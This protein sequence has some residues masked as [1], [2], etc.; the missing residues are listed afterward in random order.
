[1]FRYL[2]LVFFLSVLFCVISGCKKEQQ[3]PPAVNFTLN[4]VDPLAI[5]FSATAQDV[6]ASN[7]K[8][9]GFVWR[10]QPMPTKENSFVKVMN[11]A[12]VNFNFKLATGLEADSTYYA[13]AY[14][15]TKSKETIY[16]QEISFK[17]KKGSAINFQTTLGEYTWDDE[18]EVQLFNDLD[19][20][21]TK[22]EFVLDKNLKFVPLKI[23]GN[24]IY[25]KIPLEAN[26]ASWYSMLDVQLY[27]A[28]IASVPI[29]FK[30]P[31]IIQS[32][33]IYGT[34]GEKI[35]L[36]G[37]NFHPLK[38]R[39]T[40]LFGNNKFVVLNATKTTLE[41]EIAD[42]QYSYSDKITVQTSPVL[43]TISEFNAKVYKHFKRIAPFP[44]PARISP[45]V[46]EAN[47][48]MY[49]GL[50]FGHFASILQDMWEYT[51]ATDSWKQIADLP[52]VPGYSKAMVIDGKIYV[53]PASVII[54]NQGTNY[55]FNYDSGTN[56]WKKVS[57]YPNYPLKGM[58]AFS[59][60]NYGYLLS[61]Y[62]YDSRNYQY[63][64]SYVM[65]YD[66]LKNL[67]K[68]IENFPGTPRGEATVIKIG[69]KVTLLAGD[70]YNFSVGPRY[71]AD[72]WSFD[73]NTEKWVKLKDLSPIV[74]TPQFSFT[75]NG[76]GY[77][78][79]AL[80]NTNS[81]TSELIEY[82]PETDTY[83]KVDNLLDQNKVFAGAAA[84]G[85][86][87]YILCGDNNSGNRGTNVILRFIP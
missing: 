13:R 50:G 69:N 72:S 46:F 63:V 61:G 3:D 75:V 81:V 17:G 26:P 87:G 20:D 77:I 28:H 11:N 71:P 23:I 7:I 38:D 31:K 19:I 53:V 66:P 35:K 29:R 41:V 40:V 37:D 4:S 48:K 34:V 14:L 49:L 15:I 18:L 83:A 5:Q 12:T 67:W 47:N 57:D 70:S 54:G 21:L 74:N 33:E 32:Q 59:S 60:N 86:V 16:S 39:N 65:R 2:R 51:P 82:N 27:G 45:L 55:V 68:V 62:I 78:G 64:F 30:I 85:N 8:E 1:M 56:T 76:K 22:L 43:K 84:V 10:K 52:S 79:S 73:L 80:F 6:E 9:V 25:F 58:S 42:T 36:T 24:T 44:G